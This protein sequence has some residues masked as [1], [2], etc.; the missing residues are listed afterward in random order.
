MM[1]TSCLACNNIACKINIYS[2]KIY[3][4]LKD[5]NRFSDVDIFYNT[6]LTLSMKCKIKNSK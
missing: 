1:T 2:K 5:Q 6:L 3:N 4:I